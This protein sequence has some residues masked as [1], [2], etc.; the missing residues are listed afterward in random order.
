VDGEEATEWEVNALCGQYQ[1]PSS[2][3]T[4]AAARTTTAGL[5]VRGA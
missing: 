2:D 1:Q 4:H 5:A 3:G